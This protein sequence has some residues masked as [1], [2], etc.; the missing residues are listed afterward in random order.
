MARMNTFF[1]S[2]HS[3]N[4]LSGRQFWEQLFSLNEWIFALDPVGYVFM[5]TLF[6]SVINAISVNGAHIF[7][8]L[9][10][11]LPLSS[12]M[13]YLEYV[14]KWSKDRKGKKQRPEDEKSK[15]LNLRDAPAQGNPCLDR[16]PT[17]HNLAGNF[18]PKCG[19]A[20]QKNH[21]S[22]RCE[23]GNKE[24]DSPWQ[25]SVPWIPLHN[26]HRGA[27]LA[28]MPVQWDSPGTVAWADQLLL[29]WPPATQRDSSTS[30][31]RDRC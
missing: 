3:Q 13:P 7:K 23:R 18:I 31:R 10:I 4:A 28:S 27:S 9:H 5:D 24:M 6:C 20:H 16:G 15:A 2:C 11:L 30:R 12:F 21:S 26:F 25:S 22:G 8:S 1:F 14:L 19:C 29:D 17:W